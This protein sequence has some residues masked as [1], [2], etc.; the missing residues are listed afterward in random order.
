LSAVLSV[1]AGDQIHLWRDAYVDQ[2]GVIA[3]SGTISLTIPEPT[4]G[5]LAAAGLGLLLRRRRA[6]AAGVQAA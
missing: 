1:K 3:F 4:A 5:A 2:Q 6:R